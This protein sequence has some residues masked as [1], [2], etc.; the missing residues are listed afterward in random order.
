[1]KQRKEITIGE[2]TLIIESGYL[3]KQA[4]GS[5]TVRLGDTVVLATAC[6]ENKGGVERDFL[7]LTVDYRE[8]T[9][10]AGRIPGGF[11]K[12]EGR[13]S[14]KEI[15][16]S[17]QID[18]P[19]RP[20]FPEGYFA[21]TQIISF[22]LSADGENDPDIL[23]ING[24]SVALVL[25][26]IPFYHPVGAVR[27][28][29]IDGQV[30]MN[31]TNSLRD[32]SDLD[33]VVVG[34]EDAVVMVEA[35]ANQVSE[36]LIL[37]CIW[38]GHQE[39]QKII[40]AQH[41]LFRDGNR[42][43]PSWTAPE[44]YPESLYEQVKGDLYA[45][46]KA[47]LFTKKKFERKDAVG[48]VVKS[49]IGGIPEDE[50]AKKANVKKIVGRL[51]EEILREVVLNDRIRFDS[52]RLDEVRPIEIEIGVLPRTH[53]SAVFTRGETQALATATLGTSRDA[54]VI[55]EYEGESIQK[56]LLHYNFP[57]FS[58]G[59]VKFLR[60]PGR[61]EI[62]HGVLARRALL[63]VLPHEDEFP[64]TL[65]VVSDILE[66]NGSSSMATVCGGSLAMFDAGV[67]L[68]A[69]VAGVAMGLIKGDD[70]FAVLTD[71]AGQED[72]YGDMDF[73]VA[74]TRQGVT[75]LQMD[76]KITGVTREIMR[77]ALEQ[78]KAG[79]MHILGIMEG[80]IPQA[81]TDISKFAPR[82]YT[83]QISKE[84]I[85]DVIGPGGKTIRS[86]IEETGCNIEIEDDGR[87]VIAS[88]DEPAARRAIQMVE[89]LTQVPELGKIY[90]GTVRRIEAYGA[91]VEIMPGTDGLV[92]ISEL[93]PYRVREVTDL[94]KEG[95]EIEVKVVNIDEQGKIRLSRKA[96]IM[97]SP[98]YDPS[99]YEGME[100]AMAGGG[101]ER[102]E[103]D[104]G[105]DRGG[106]GGDR[107]GRGG[108]GG[109][110]GGRGGAG[111]G[112]SGDRGGRGG[113]R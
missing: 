106:R 67:P 68:L 101:G 62:G 3:A 29:L 46:L 59:E 99:Q 85:R 52:R 35:G 32:V 80:A 8:Y 70:T 12:R 94:L 17:R 96:V 13:P 47:A 55:E 44:V 30:V 88:P 4:N 93:A 72:H 41:E 57:P 40:K 83:L 105:G 22:C 11:F 51:E 87:V 61:R 18:R 64:Y 90:T 5:C 27:V 50:A 16:T 9:Y 1:M 53:G 97:E 65:R 69:P 79:R 33:L 110:R 38:R 54:Q 84:K 73:K 56:F 98:D 75:A 6:M 48:A 49:Y 76:M 34:T 14:E 63:P 24:A 74:G 37:E 42:E 77:V 21:D 19:L 25:S 43:K 66:S 103:G 78:A 100:M 10:A 104:R 92:H 20:L 95:D 91:F 15:I 107:G 7:P 45:P 2:G 81:R 36:E 112:R 86:I 82:L 26:N 39:I 102:A 71:I 60:S 58:V 31:P 113:N 111:G 89:R 108:G 28:G 23:A 109:F